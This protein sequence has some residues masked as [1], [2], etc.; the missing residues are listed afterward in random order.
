MTQVL[1]ILHLTCSI[2]LERVAPGGCVVFYSIAVAAAMILVLQVR[3]MSEVGTMSI[4]GTITILG[5]VGIIVIALP[6]RGGTGGG[7]NFFVPQAHT[8]LLLMA[9]A[10]MDIVFSFAGQIIYIELLSEMKQPKDFMKAMVS[11][12]TVMFAC[13]AVV[14]CLGSIAAR[15]FL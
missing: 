2:S 8:T 1:V 4:V 7:E 15:I 3:D 11:S 13:Y 9:I 14:G 12:N 10:F 5:V 6:V